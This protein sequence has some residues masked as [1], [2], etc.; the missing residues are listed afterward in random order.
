M[1]SLEPLGT[2]LSGPD[3]NPRTTSFTE[4]GCP[5]FSGGTEHFTEL[6]LIKGQAEILT[7]LQEVALA[8]GDG[9]GYRNPDFHVVYTDVYEEE[10]DEYNAGWKD[11]QEQEDQQP[12]VEVL[13]PGGGGTAAT[14]AATNAADEKLEHISEEGIV[15]IDD[16]DNHNNNRDGGKGNRV[17]DVSTKGV[18]SDGKEEGE[19]KG[20]KAAANKPESKS[21][22]Q[23]QDKIQNGGAKDGDQPEQ[24]ETRL[25][26]LGI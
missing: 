13:V 6:L 10:K 11:W 5:V 20:A 8:D 3:G 22:V 24:L 26:G 14:A 25:R 4:L 7:F 19:E 18:P 16:I 17:D 1:P 2:I 23:G 12:V 21:E 15:E 9:Y